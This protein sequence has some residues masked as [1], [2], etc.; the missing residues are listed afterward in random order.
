MRT[1]FPR[2]AVIGVLS[3]L[4]FGLL[5]GLITWK[6]RNSRRGIFLSASA[7]LAVGIAWFVLW[8]N[9]FA[10]VSAGFSQFFVWPGISK[11]LIANFGAFLPLGLTIAFATDFSTRYRR[12]AL[13]T[14]VG[15]PICL[16]LAQATFTELNR[17]PNLFDIVAD[18][19]GGLLGY[20]VGATILKQRNS[21]R[22]APAVPDPSK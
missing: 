18:V 5:L 19:L 7:V 20:L 21:D 14:I 12:I 11:D 10:G 1:F 15:L 2:L 4:A 8:P 3:C 9:S 6:R 13:L 22:N 16:E 17:T